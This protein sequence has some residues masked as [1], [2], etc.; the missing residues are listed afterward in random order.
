VVTGVRSG[1]EGYYSGY[2][3]STPSRPA[4]LVQPPG[5]S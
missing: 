2:Y 3:S 4:T 1:H 5:S